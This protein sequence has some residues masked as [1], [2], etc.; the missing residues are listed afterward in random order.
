MAQAAETKRRGK[1]KDKAVDRD[2]LLKAYHDMLLI[3]R[4][5]EKAGQLY[6]MGLIGGFCHLYIGQEAVVVG[7]QLAL[8]DGDEVITSYRDHGH[9][10]ATG[11][12]ARGVMAELTGRSGGYS[13]G[14]GG[15]MHMFSKEKKF[16]GGHGIVGAQVPIG[17]GLGFTHKHRKDGLLAMCFLGDGAVNQGQ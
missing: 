12:E 14:K 11:M 5:E 16:F 4:F 17:T 7:M 1:T 2:D 9:M 13:R 3:R 8:T 10:L 15:S 6:G